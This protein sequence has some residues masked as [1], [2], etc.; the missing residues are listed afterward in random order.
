MAVLATL[1]IEWDGAEYTV[2]AMPES[3][4]A[5]HQLAMLKGAERTLERAVNAEKLRA[6]EQN[7]WSVVTRELWRF[8]R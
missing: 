1:Y 6:A 3:L 7:A 4:P 5:S 2:T 8:R